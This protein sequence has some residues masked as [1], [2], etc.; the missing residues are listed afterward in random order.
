MSRRIKEEHRGCPICGKTILGRD[1]NVEY[2]LTRRGI[3]IWFHR[4]CYLQNTRGRRNE[5]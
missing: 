1:K 5:D 2:S 4:S 3:K